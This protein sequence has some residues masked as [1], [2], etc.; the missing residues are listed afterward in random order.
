MAADWTEAHVRRVF[1]RAGFGARPDEVAKWTAAGKDATLR[2][3]LNGDGGPELVGPE[4]RT[5][6]GPLD[7]VNEWGHDGLWW[8]D[9]M[10]RSQRPLVEKMTLFWH[11]HFATRDQEFSDLTERELEVLKLIA[12]GLSNAEIGEQLFLSEA[13]VKTHVTR[14]LAKLGLRDRVQA[15]VRAYETGLVEPGVEP[16][17]E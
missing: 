2:W 15:V 10:V 16:A 17:P 14:I 6:D 8:L 5:G 4:P 13:T 12:R 7:P 9:R 11:D 3:L 1:W